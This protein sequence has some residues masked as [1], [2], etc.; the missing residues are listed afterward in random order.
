[1][2]LIF[3]KE[4]KQKNSKEASLKGMTFGKEIKDREKR[5]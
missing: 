5:S 2:K 1:M 4:I 3:C